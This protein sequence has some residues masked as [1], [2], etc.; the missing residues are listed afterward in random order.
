[1]KRSFLASLA[2]AGLLA[3]A[4]AVVSAQEAAPADAPAAA[5]PAE[6]GQI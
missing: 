2:L 3:F 6:A 5:A 1:M 4:P